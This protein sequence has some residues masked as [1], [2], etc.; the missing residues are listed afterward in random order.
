MTK[1]VTVWFTG[2]SGS[3]KTTIA[4]RVEQLLHERGVHA[5]RLDG[6]VVRQ[7]LTRDLGFSK[8]DRDKNIE[9]VTFVAKLLTRNDV[10]VLSSFISPYRAQRENARREIGQFLEVYVSASI[11]TLVSRDLKG[12]YKKAMAGEIQG[13]TGVNDPYEAPES[14]DLVCDTDTESVDESVAKVIGLLEERGYIPASGGAMLGKRGQRE[15]VP[16]PSVPHGGVLVNRELTGAAR[17]EALA[18][19]A[20]L[21]T[22]QLGEKELS[23]L[24]MIGIGA[25]SP[26]TGFMRK[27]DYECVVDSM[28]LSDGLVW[29]LPVTLAVTAEQAAAI[30]EGEEIALTDADGKIVG[31]MQVTEKYGYDKEREARQCFG[32]TEAAHPGVARVYAQ[33][34]V[35]LAGPVWVLDR[36]NQESFA[37]YRLT[38]LETRR[39][40]DEMGWK[41]VVAFQTRNPVHRA[42]E[43]LQKCAME[44]VDGLLLHPLVGATKSDDV[45]ADV[46]MQT[47]RTILDSYYPKQRAMLSVFPAAMRYAGPREAVWHA[48][49]RKNYGCTHFIVGRDHAGVGSYYGTYDAQNMIDRF[50]FEELGITPLKFEHSFFCRAC[51]NMA[52]AKTC[53]HGQEHH[54]HLSGTKVRTMLGNGE[55]PPPE[56]SRPEV[57][58]ILIEAYR[59]AAQEAVV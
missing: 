29:A 10:V 13:F 37:E 44:M 46:R 40:F 16:G 28:R 38:P 23:D 33:G 42:H 30:R 27:L 25:L 50:S 4:K 47:Y 59:S 24:E 1:G 36:P 55:L 51:G 14:P 45:P 12:L 41:S 11:D 15:R 3:G 39:K 19:A 2:L 54:L 34:E 48:I 8:E 31:T 26:L 20:T 32:T 17:D 22:V 5:E 56:F 9:R 57:A 18:R 49:C 21:R 53:P 52:S 58:K 43:Y 6:D 7:S 35:Y